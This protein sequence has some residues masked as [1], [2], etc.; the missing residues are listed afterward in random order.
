MTRSMIESGTDIPLELRKLLQEI[1]DCGNSFGV[2][3]N[4]RRQEIEDLI[5]LQGTTE[6][7]RPRSTYR[8]LNHA[9]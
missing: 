6:V 1:E 8:V 3:S 4:Q 7:T 9:M 5:K 2:V